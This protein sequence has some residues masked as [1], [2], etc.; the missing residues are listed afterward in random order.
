MLQCTIT[1]IA[2]SGSHQTNPHQVEF[3]NVRQQDEFLNLERE[4]DLDNYQEGSLQTVHT[5]GNGFRRKGHAV[6]E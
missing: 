6:H 1:V 5:G 2:G 3:I 4:K